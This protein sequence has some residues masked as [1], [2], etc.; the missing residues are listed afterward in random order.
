MSLINLV[1]EKPVHLV[2]AK[3]RVRSVKRGHPWIFP[4]VLRELPRAPA[5]SLALLKTADGEILAKGYYDPASKLAFRT[6]ALQKDKL[7]ESLIAA[8]L[9]R[10]AALRDALFAPFDQTN[11]FRLINGEGDGLPGLVVDVYNDSAVVKLDGAGAEAFY[12]ANGLAAWLQ[13]RLAGRLATVYMKY[14]TASGVKEEEERGRLL[15]GVAPSAERP[16]RFVENGVQFQADIVQG[17][18]TGFFLDQRDNRAF[19]RRLSNNKRVLNV[20]GYTGGFSVYAGV[21]GASHVTTVDVGKAALSFADAN[22]ALNGLEPSR[23]VAAAEDAFEFLERAGKAR[24]KWEV[25]IIDPPSFAPSKQAVEKA[26]ASYTRLF[27]AA[28]S[29][30]APHG[31]LALASCS[32]HIDSAMFMEICDEALGK[33]RRQGYVLGVGGQPADHPYPAAADELRYLKFVTFRLEN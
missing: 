25:V 17:Q 3:D 7:D 26:K 13:Q 22:W 9:G 30:T 16:A 10:A 1:N 31:T 33:A 5:G 19:I 12:N 29:V 24:E 27:A 20:F 8:R 6:F 2:L 4:E 15:A 21:G 23:H 32:S 28:A 11:G 18:K 14:R